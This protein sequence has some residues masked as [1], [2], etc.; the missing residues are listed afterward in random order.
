[1]ELTST[2]QRLLDTRAAFIQARNQANESQLKVTAAQ[3]EWSM[4]R[5]ELNTEDQELLA[6]ITK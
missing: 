5:D 1:M 3:K 2:V 4:A 6:P